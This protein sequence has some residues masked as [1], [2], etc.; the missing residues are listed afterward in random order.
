VATG[1]GEKSSQGAAVW[2]TGPNYN[3][4]QTDI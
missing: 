3:R 4:K 2:G 1:P